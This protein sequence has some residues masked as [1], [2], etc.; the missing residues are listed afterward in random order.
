MPRA[1]A[2]GFHRP[3]VH[4]AHAGHSSSRTRYNAARCAADRG[5]GKSSRYDAASHNTAY[6]R[7]GNDA[8]TGYRA[9][10]AGFGNTGNTGASDADATAQEGFVTAD[11][12]VRITQNRFL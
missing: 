11:A 12:A 9:K 3:G 5:A 7:S 2:N 1:S 6:Q 4:D 8:G 10:G